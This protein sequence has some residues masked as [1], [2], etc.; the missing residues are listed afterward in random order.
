[1]EE[2]TRVAR[3]PA[4]GKHEFL[5][6]QDCRTPELQRT[7]QVRT[8]ERQRERQSDV[9]NPHRL[10]GELSIPE[11]WNHRR[12]AVQLGEYLDRDALWSVDQCWLQ[13]HGRNSRPSYQLLRLPF[14]AVVRRCALVRARAERA[15]MNEPPHPSRSRCTEEA[16]GAV[17]V[18][19]GERGR[20]PL[21]DDADQMYGG[22][23]AAKQASEGGV[24][25][26]GARDELSALGLEE[27]RTGGI[28]DQGA[29]PVTATQEQ[30]GEMPAYKPG[31]TGDGN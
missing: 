5:V 27:F 24:V 23:S 15:H 10:D 18:H 12:Q 17:H 9:F 14:G 1:M 11:D 4:D 8:F 2:A 16:S 20:S 6:G 3:R 31:S 30:R 19:R 29:D 25:V 21:D 7:C 22:V 28:P 26:E 13:D